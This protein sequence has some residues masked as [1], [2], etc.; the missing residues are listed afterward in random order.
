[1][2]HELKEIYKD[3]NK[4]F[5]TLEVAFSRLIK[6]RN[7][8]Q[9]ILKYECSTKDTAEAVKFLNS[10]L[11]KPIDPEKILPFLNLVYA[12]VLRVGDPEIYGTPEIFEG[13]NYKPEHDE[14]IMAAIEGLNE[15]AEWTKD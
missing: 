9:D 13:K 8:L 12:D 7:K 3:M 5:K 11:P 6:A 10:K 2:T 15:A 14:E 4:G 1:M